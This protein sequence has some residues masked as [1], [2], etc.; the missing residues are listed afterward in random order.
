MWN[1]E[2][3]TN[4]EM[5]IISAPIPS[6]QIDCRPINPSFIPSAG[7]QRILYGKALL[8]DEIDPSFPL[9]D[10]Y[11]NGYVGYMKAVTEERNG[12]ICNRCGTADRRYFHSYPCADCRGECVYCRNCIMMGKSRT[13]AKLVT[14]TGPPAAFRKVPEPLQWQGRLSMC[15]QE[16]SNRVTEAVKR[17]ETCL[18]WAVCG[19][20]KTEVL[21]QGIGVA[22]Q[23]GQRLCIAT[24]RTDVVLELTPRLKRA[25]P[26]TSIAALYGGSEDKQLCAQLV[27]STTH[28]LFR[29]HQAFDTVIIDEVDAFPYSTDR[30]LQYAVSK[31]RKA[32]SSLIYL[33][34]TPS[35]AMQ[36][37]AMKNKLAYVTIPA[38][39]HRHSIPVPRLKWCG[40]WHKAFE[41]GNI[42][43]LLLAWYLGQLQTMT[44]FL[45]F[46]PNIALMK[47]YSS[48]FR[49]HYPAIASVYAE[50]ERRKEKVSDLRQ[51]NVLG[52]LTTTILERGVTIPKLSV[53]VLGAEEEIF[54]ESALVQIAGR[55]GRSAEHP[56]GD[57]TFFH[58]G[59]T[60]AIVKAVRQI[61]RM[62]KEAR[63]RGLIDD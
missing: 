58:Y 47:R 19:A 17:N 45:I 18:V 29:Y 48:L 52:L 6:Y 26:H 55:V 35:A 30:S 38:R 13:C 40:D 25:F 44:P 36:K 2:R 33:T 39:F 27:I 7:L 9:N 49:K 31:S 43:S 42:P 41:R 32:I 37:E 46:F 20:G 12:H 53:A 61:E 4:K 16:A 28:Q 57:V 3:I 60:R 34:A 63:Q 62:N 14:W 15:Q 8:Q 5:M 59:K 10:H 21:F 50:D 51:G 11:Q 56:R 22:L 1:I 54:T 23:S 24:P